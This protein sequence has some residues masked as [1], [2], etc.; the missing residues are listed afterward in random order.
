MA[1]ETTIISWKDVGVLAA[2]VERETNRH[3]VVQ[4]TTVTSTRVDGCLSITV[5][6]QPVEAI[7]SRR[8]PVNA[9]GHYPSRGAKSVTGLLVKLLYEVLEKANRKDGAL[10]EATQVGFATD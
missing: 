10:L 2:Q 9:L 5:R 7:R 8:Q 6:L 3:V 1:R 4:F